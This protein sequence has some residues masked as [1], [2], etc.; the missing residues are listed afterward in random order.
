MGLEE[1]HQEIQKEHPWIWGFIFGAI[2]SIGLALGSIMAGDPPPLPQLALMMSVTA[3][4]AGF[5]AG[6]IRR[7]VNRK[8]D[9]D[10]S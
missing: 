8:G 4:I 9:H 2:L 3:T 1:K 6:L 10:R 7:N 5:A